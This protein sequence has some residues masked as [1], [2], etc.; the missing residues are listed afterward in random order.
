[1]PATESPATFVLPDR[2]D[3]R[4]RPQRLQWFPRAFPGA[5]L[6]RCEV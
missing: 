2:S 4:E 3:R 5:A 1:M 6:P